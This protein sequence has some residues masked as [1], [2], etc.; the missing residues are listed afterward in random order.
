[1]R[2]KNISRHTV[3]LVHTVTDSSEATFMPFTQNAFIVFKAILSFV[4]VVVVLIMNVM[5]FL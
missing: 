4:V 1:M 3:F 5:A 2:G